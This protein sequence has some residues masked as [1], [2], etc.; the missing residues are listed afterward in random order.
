L[1]YETYRILLDEPASLPGLGFPAYADAFADIIATSQPR[2]AIGIFGGWGSG[3]TT[4]MRAIEARLNERQDIVTIWFNA[5]RFEHE[6]NMI[7]PLI[8]VLRDAL[9]RLAKSS[10]EPRRRERARIAADRIARAGRALLASITVRAAI[11]G[12]DIELDGGKLTDALEL[13]TSGGQDDSPLS[14]YQ[15]GFTMLADAIKEFAD[16]GADR[17]AIFIDDLDRCLPTKALEVLESMKVF[18]DTAGIIFIVGLDRTVVEQAVRAKFGLAD[19]TAGSSVQS[20]EYIKKIFQVPF[21]LPRITTSM[22]TDYLDHIAARGEL[23]PPQQADFDE[24]VRPHLAFLI[25]DDTVN[26]REVK[27]LINAYTLQLRMLSGR[28]SHLDPEVVMA[29]QCLSF[30]PDWEDLYERLLSDPALFQQAIKDARSDPTN[31]DAVWLGGERVPVPPSFRTYLDGP[32]GA[33]ITAPSLEQHVVAVEATRSAD[34]GILEMHIVLGRLRREIENLPTADLSWDE[35]SDL[36]EPP[37]IDDEIRR[38]FD[39]VER[40]SQRYPV[41]LSAES[42]QLTVLRREFPKRRRG[43]EPDQYRSEISRG[44][45][46]TAPVLDGIDS[47]LRELRRRTTVGASHDPLGQ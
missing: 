35:Q 26:P 34:P 14:F 37:Q 39:T 40:H 31:F 25:G 1:S 21:A 41:E 12:L 29:L 28:M 15:A 43:Q 5:W 32:G 2:F 47:V 24:N 20:I 8:D 3:K 17:I 10:P 9:S 23:S 13:D 33:L 19:G 45:A 4:L 44:V 11:P 16:R 30:R 7:V 27:R 18:F 22:L 38:L 36:I 6:G 46:G 42:R